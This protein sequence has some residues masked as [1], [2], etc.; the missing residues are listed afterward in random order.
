MATR[1]NEREKLLAEDADTKR[2]ATEA[3]KPHDTVPGYAGPDAVGETH[4]EPPKFPDDFEDEGIVIGQGGTVTHPTKVTL[5]TPSY[6]KAS[7]D[8]RIAGRALL[9][10]RTFKG[11]DRKIIVDLTE[12]V[13][14]E[15][16]FN[17]F[18][19]H[20]PD[21]IFDGF[22]AKPVTE[23]EAKKLIEQ[24]KKE[25]AIPGQGPSGSQKDDNGGKKKG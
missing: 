24:W 4:K 7:D 2:R 5:A 9:E 17:V 15:G 11:Y 22:K 13:T 6:K 16:A 8:E 10:G 18:R 19:N 3:P 12:A 20:Y 14:Q 1:E 23:E 21:G 25:G